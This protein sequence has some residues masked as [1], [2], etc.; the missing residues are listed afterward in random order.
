MT[1]WN[2][3]VGKWF[4]NTLNG[5]H[6]NLL[7]NFFKFYSNI[8]LFK[9][10]VLCTSTGKV[11]EKKFFFNKFGQLPAA[12]DTKFK[13]FKSKIAVNFSLFCGLV[14]QDPFDLSFNIT[15]NITINRLTNF[16]EMCDKTVTILLNIK[17][18]PL[19]DT[20]Q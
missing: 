7:L 5:P 11:L 13:D 10:N 3:M 18:D 9:E 14:L 17:N 12:K 15:K 1:G 4:G 20:T 16:C 2:C 8:N 19:Q 6:Y